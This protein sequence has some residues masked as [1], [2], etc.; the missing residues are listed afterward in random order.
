MSNLLKI[1]YNNE[2]VFE[3]DRNTRLP[4]KRR[5]FLDMMDMDMDEGIIINGDLIELPDQNHR[6]KYVAMNL[7]DGIQRHDDSLIS[8]TATYLGSRIPALKEIIATECNDD[9]SMELIYE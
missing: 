9:I 8:V 1:I 3:Y 7:I 5:Q 6:A 2:T 4:G